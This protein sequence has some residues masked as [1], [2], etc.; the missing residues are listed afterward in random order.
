[1]RISVCYFLI[2]LSTY[3]LLHFLCICMF[4]GMFL[5]REILSLFLSIYLFLPVCLSLSIQMISS[6]NYFAFF[7]T[8]GTRIS[9][10]THLPNFVYASLRKK[11]GH[12]TICISMC[13][14]SLRICSLL[15]NCIT[16]DLLTYVMHT[17]TNK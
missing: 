8:F 1:M 2:Y 5:K 12:L 17:H 14:F 13:P 9:F 4:F 7:S 15:F 10:H 3:L 16:V 11:F 6:S